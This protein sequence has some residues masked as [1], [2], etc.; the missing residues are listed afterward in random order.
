MPLDAEI[1]RRDDD[2]ARQQRRDVP[3]TAV[4]VSGPGREQ[5]HRDRQ[6][7]ERRE[8][9][10]VAV[11]LAGQQLVLGVG[12]EQQRFDRFGHEVPGTVGDERQITDD[13]EAVLTP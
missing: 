5:R 2:A 4:S 9:V 1:R 11:D 10:G 12:G 7:R 6:R 8:D 3:P 13:P